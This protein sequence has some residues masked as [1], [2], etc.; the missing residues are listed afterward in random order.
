M[1]ARGLGGATAGRYGDACY[2][3]APQIMKTTKLRGEIMSASPDEF[4]LLISSV[5]EG[6]IP[7][8]VRSKRLGERDR[9]GI[10]LFQYDADTGAET[11]AVQVKTVEREIKPRHIKAFRKEI[12]KFQKLGPTVDEYW[13]VI[14]KPLKVASERTE[15]TDD[16]AGLVT[17]GKA[18]KARLLDQEGLIKHL[19]TLARGR[20]VA[21]SAE[22][23]ANLK[24]AYATRLQV[25]KYIQDVPYSAA[26]LDWNPAAAIA[27]GARA[28]LDAVHQDQAGR[29]RNP[30]R[31]LI[32]SGFGFG[33]TTTLH[34]V[35]E[36]WVAAGGHALYVP[37]A[38]LPQR[39]FANGAGL[40]DGLLS[41][42][43]PADFP[44]QNPTK[45]LLRDTLR[46][47][48]ERS[49]DWILLIDAIDE[50]PHWSSQV[51]LAA[52]WAG[53]AALG[54]PTVVSV[55]EEVYESRRLEFDHRVVRK[56]A[57]D[58]FERFELLDWP[59]SLI[60]TFLDQFATERAPAAPSA[61]FRR[62]REAVRTEAY[63]E[64][65]GDIP[66]RPL[67]L[68]M[69]AED[70]WNGADPEQDLSR[71]YDKYFRRKLMTD[72]SGA[73]AG[74]QVVR[75]GALTERHGYED[76][77]ER[78]MQAMQAVATEILRRTNPDLPAG[79]ITAPDLERCLRQSLGEFANAEE[80]LLISVLRPA[81][82][83]PSTRD[84]LFSFAHQSFFDWFV[85]KSLIAEHGAAADQWATNDAVRLFLKTS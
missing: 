59:P 9:L 74:G 72:W 52:L 10:D 34:A 75:A 83:H 65:Y 55:R 69:L 64:L 2:A 38:L 4:D 40:V 49:R 78:M 27:K 17:S 39:A 11:L 76:T 3:D 25:V 28:F 24:E 48:L 47:D 57:G 67:F 58:F 84:R 18:A 60:G 77:I 21:W 63:T 31:V 35:A 13:L 66:R 7:R 46:A 79:V 12:A 32:A 5:A 56:A 1:P 82:R 68:S 8:F 29:E 61:A 14:N 26:S 22:L 16:L 73:G 54:I 20:L 70:A 41:T 43:A 45:R 37:A 42:I 23:Q 6:L 80:V 44:L 50:S 53:V 36:R 15:L 81:G 33:K 62:F 51:H 19:E 30:P 71:L 85:A